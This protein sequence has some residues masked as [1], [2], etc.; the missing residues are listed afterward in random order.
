MRSIKLLFTLHLVALVFGLAGLLIALPHPELWSFN[1]ALVAV[2]S[3]GI[4]Y[5]GSLH[6]LFGAATVL[7]FGLRFI[8]PR[9]TLIFFAAAT[10]ISLSMELIG[11][12]TGFPFG[13][14]SYTDFLGFKILGHV[15]YAIPLSWFY[16]G[17]TAYVLAQLLLARRMLRHR[18]LWTLLLGAY[19]LTVWDLTLDPAMASANLPLHFWQW[20]VQGIYFGMPV[21]NLVG[22]SVTGLLY[23][24]VSRLFWRSDLPV[25]TGGRLVAWLPFGIYA[26]NTLFAIALDLSVGLWQPPLLGLFLGIAPAALVL[27]PPDAPL[28][29]VQRLTY[30][31]ASR[32]MRS[33]A[34]LLMRGRVTLV[35]EGVDAVPRR[36]PALIAARHYHHLYDGCALLRTLARPLH[37]LVA[38]DW[39][40]TPWQRWRM[41]TL[42]ALA[43]WP[44]MLRAERLHASA[45][46][47]AYRP[48][49]S[50][51]YLR[52]SLR[53]ALELLQGGELLVVFPEGYPLIDPRPS[54]RAPGEELLPFRAGFARLV[55]LAEQRTG[56]TVP[57]IPA[58]LSM[59]AGERGPFTLRFGAPLLRS[60]YA[61]TAQFIAA[62]ESAVRTLSA[63]ER[64]PQPHAGKEALRS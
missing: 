2:F 6:I 59:E 57:V 12:T 19:L 18:T 7:L 32:I 37:I 31:I 64:R 29:P 30:R 49:E 45:T 35:V 55:E 3:F 47:Q 40:R 15:P 33:G 61:N 43:G 27:F 23:M 8:G 24:S 58:G 1:P 34:T 52:R 41:E 63:L 9:K 62:V 54:P 25:G 20:G 14:Y 51:S 36:G 60:N 13:P 26:A 21:Q 50:A 10:L 17:L 38:L 11:T 22:W 16:M 4:R 56:L 44:V 46:G 42:C 28:S 5:A 39:V 53:R 48:A